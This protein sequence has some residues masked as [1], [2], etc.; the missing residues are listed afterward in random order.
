MRNIKKNNQGVLLIIPVLVIL[1]TF[2]VVNIAIAQ[3]G[4]I[5]FEIREEW[6]NEPSGVGA[7]VEIMLDTFG[8]VGQWLTM[9]YDFFGFLGSK[10]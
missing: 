7:G 5:G 4:K 6:T 10:C 2:M 9:D 3:E 1:S 8:M